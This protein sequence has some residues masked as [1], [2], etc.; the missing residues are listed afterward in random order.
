M[1]A[2]CLLTITSLQAQDLINY[3]DSHLM[4]FCLHCPTVMTVGEILTLLDVPF[5]QTGKARE[6]EVVSMR[7]CTQTLNIRQNVEAPNPW[8]CM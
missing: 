8:G 4:K 1:A 5:L 3:E 6:R 7:A 2:T